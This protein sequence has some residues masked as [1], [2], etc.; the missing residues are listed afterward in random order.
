M[1]FLSEITTWLVVV[2]ALGAVAGLT[3]IVTSWL[4]AGSRG[5]KMFAGVIT[6]GIKDLVLL[7]PRR[8]FAITSLTVRESVRRKALWIGAVFL[9]LFMF[10]GWFIGDA[11]ESTPA[12]PYISFVMT[13]T[14]WMLLPVAVLLSCWGLPAD[15][16]DRSL[17]TVVTKPVRRSEVV[18]G[19]IA[20]YVAVM[21]TL[22]LGVSLVG[23]LWVQRVVPERAQRQLVSRVPIGGSGRTVKSTSTEEMEEIRRNVGDQ[24]DIRQFIEG[25][26]TERAVFVFDEIHEDLFPGSDDIRLEYRFEA[27]RS[28]KGDLN[29]EIEFA[30]EV[31]N[32]KTKARAAIGVYP[33]NEFSTEFAHVLNDG[34]EENLILLSRKLSYIPEGADAPIEADLFKDFI[35]DGQLKVEIACLD[36]QQYLGANSSDL[37]IRLPDRPF[38]SGFWKSIFAM[39][40]ALVLTVTIGTTSSCFLK[41]PVSTLATTGLLVLG[42]FLKTGLL[43][44]LNDFFLQGQTLGG[45]PVEAFFRTIWG[46]N[47]SSPMDASPTTAA[48]Q[49][50]DGVVFNLL[51]VFQHLIPSLTVFDGTPYI[52]NGFDV[53]LSTCILPSLF[54]TIGFFIPCY[55]IGYF[56]LQLRELEA[57]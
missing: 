11:K 2:L 1:N 10:A 42:T 20:G 40:L 15:I 32:E 30:A 56:A 50:I 47:E 39:W 51:N 52:A 17:H 6:R 53:P 13:T 43:S 25:A 35:V 8:I 46:M 14:R 12:K 27:F 7:S 4:M 49:F 21:T 55:I 37:F 48:I 44:R 26:T 33:V 3:G 9:L 54:I 23:F 16:R 34:K 38:A 31:V 19:R 29:T 41:G 28:Y 18:L 24:L 5:V 57:K 22:L 36:S 45:G